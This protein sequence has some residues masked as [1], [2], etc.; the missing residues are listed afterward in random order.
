M[1]GRFTLFAKLE[2]LKTEFELKE[3]NSLPSSYNIA[4]SQS[5]LIISQDAETYGK[6]LH[7]AHWGLI[8]SW[9]KNPHEAPKPINARFE[10]LTEK[11]YYKKSFQR[12]RCLIPTTGFYEWTSSHG[13]KQ[14]Y[15]FY[16]KDYKPFAL[17][18]IYDYWPGGVETAEIV[19]ATIITTDANSLLKPYHSRMPVIIEPHNYGHWLDPENKNTEELMAMLYPRDYEALTCHAVSQYV[20]APRNND[21]N[22]IKLV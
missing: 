14:P 10:T 17:A 20:N 7:L 13:T 16:M 12:Q 2:E 15:F 19:S 9:T 8:P 18:G 21:S 22:C 5:I 11:P 6:H 4:P 3:A 1:C